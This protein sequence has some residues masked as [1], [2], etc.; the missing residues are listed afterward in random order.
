MPRI[1]ALT[2]DL[3]NR[4]IDTIDRLSSQVSDLQTK[5]NNVGQ[6]VNISDP[7]HAPATT[8]NAHFTWTGSTTTLSW[9]TSFIKDK[10]WNAQSVASPTAISSAK[11]QQHVY[12]ITPGHLSLQPSTYYWLG[13]DHAHQTMVAT[14][15]ASSIHGNHAVHIICQL[16]TGNGS[17]TGTAGGG[18]GQG[19]VDL[20]GLQYKN[21]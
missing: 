16:F 2:L 13:W 15:D 4:Q 17:Q 12:T 10:N 6:S 5:L 9:A 3:V 1:P 18:G 21:F 19:G 11:G 14:T 7:I 8:N 20:S